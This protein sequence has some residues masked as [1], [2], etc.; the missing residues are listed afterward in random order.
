MIEIIYKN[1]EKIVVNL[2]QTDLVNKIS[3]CYGDSF[4]HS[5][6]IEDC[7]AI[8]DE[9]DYDGRF[10]N[11]E[12]IEYHWN[13]ILDGLEGMKNVGNEVTEKFPS[14]FDFSQNTLNKLHRIFTYT[15]LY[16]GGEI[17]EYPYSENYTKDYGMSFEEYHSIVDKINM[18]VHNLEAWVL[19]TDNRKYLNENPLPRIQYNVSNYSTFNMK[20]CEFDKNEYQE[21]YNFLNYDFEN[22]VTL[23]DTILGKSPLASF[24]DDDNPTLPDCTGRFATDGSFQI[25]KGNQLKNIYLSDYFKQW[26]KKYNHTPYTLPLEL[27]IGYVDLDKTTQELDYF[28]NIELELESVIWK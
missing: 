15:D 12:E 11:N 6:V 10:A 25:N 7:S 21:N 13:Q 20:W 23:R 27:A 16:H 2:F 22:I 3:K 28:W 4:K 17:D 19:P 26:A 1:G 18:G 9:N 14:K 24:R 8:S 5:Y